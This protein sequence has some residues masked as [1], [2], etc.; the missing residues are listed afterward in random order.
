MAA[1]VAAASC[2]IRKSGDGYVPNGRKGRKGRNSCI[3]RNSC[4]S[5][6]SR[7][8]CNRSGC[9]ICSFGCTAVGIEGE[10]GERERERGR[11]PHIY[12]QGE[13]RAGLIRALLE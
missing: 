9:S 6:S 7:I 8:S 10:E 4:I 12:R 11:G 13:R 2:D 5:R 3:R 1:T